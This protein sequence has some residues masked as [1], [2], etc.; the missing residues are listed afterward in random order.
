MSSIAVPDTPVE[1]E[2]RARRRRRV[3]IVLLIMF[4][5][6]TYW[7]WRIVPQPAEEYADIAEHFKYGSI[8]A[9]N[10]ERGIPVRLWQV[11]PE[12]FPEHLPG[13]GKAGAGYDAFGM[14]VEP[15]Q[16]RPVGFSKRRV[17]GLEL[18]GMNCA[19]CHTGTVRATPESARQVVLGMPAN[20]VNL[21]AYVEF[22]FACAEDGRFTVDTVM[23]Q[24]RSKG[25]LDWYER[26]AYPFAIRAFREQVLAQKA[27]LDYWQDHK[28][29]P[30]FGPG[31]VDTFNPYKRLFFNMDVGDW[32]G[33]ADFPSLWHQRQ[34]EGMNLHWDGNND[35]VRERNIS[36]AIGAGVIAPN[37]DLHVRSSL[38][39]PSMARIA[40]WIMDLGPPKFP[41]A[42]IDP[43]LAKAGKAVFD[44]HC[45]A[46]HAFDG[47]MV[48]TV[49]PQSAPKLATDPHRLNSFTAAMADRMN[50]WGQG[51]AWKFSHFHKTDGYANS[52]L[53]GLWL[54]APYL[55]NGSV[56]N[57][58]A[59]LWPDQRP[60][61]FFRGN[62][63][64]DWD[65][66]GF[67]STTA[68]EGERK[69][70]EFD[71]TRPGNGNGGHTY[72]A[73]LPEDQKT[74]LL[75]YLKTL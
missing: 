31:R 42:R 4:V 65:N 29:F 68:A 25:E 44:G 64:Y 6:G 13:G 57:L 16:D 52:P 71:T 55:H 39:E 9:D 27:K 70:F 15:G 50:G 10:R 58:R 32:V 14:I 2:D 22:L 69:Y 3:L 62:D 1:A 35:L 8:G 28:K 18:V 17:F 45:A 61:R 56:P 11:L 54:R 19:V 41:A 24:M 74:S 66:V 51:Y 63:V 72:G 38:D 12:L 67:D 59:L 34:R 36:A 60:T 53:D 49:T 7:Y 46:C 21:Q 40:D 5:I 73:E 26:V 37:S 48:G 47:A 23:A 75:E 33:T 43:K 20:T 30:P